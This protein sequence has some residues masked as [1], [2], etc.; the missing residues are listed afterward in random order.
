VLVSAYRLLASLIFSG[1]NA[2]GRPP[3]LPLALAASSPAFVRSLMM[4][5]S[6]SAIS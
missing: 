4:S 5:R 2:G 1:D 3:S 6:S